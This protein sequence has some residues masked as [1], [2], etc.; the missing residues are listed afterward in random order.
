MVSGCAGLLSDTAE[1]LER[2]QAICAGPQLPPAE[3]KLLSLLPAPGT[4]VDRKTVLRVKLAYTVPKSWAGDCVL[5]ARFGWEEPGAYMLWRSNMARPTLA[6]GTETLSIPLTS[7]VDD[8]RML[9]P[10]Q[11]RFAIQFLRGGALVA[12]TEPQLYGPGT[13]A[14]VPTLVVRSLDPAPDEKLSPD[15][16]VTALLAYNIPDFVPGQYDLRPELDTVEP[17]ETHLLWDK[18][19]VVP[20][21]AASGLAVV[22]V[23]LAQLLR[24]PRSRRPLPLS[25]AMIRT[26]QGGGWRH[27]A[28]TTPARYDLCRV[29]PPPE[30]RSY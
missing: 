10:L 18:A 1:D 30:K 11:V 5:A 14:R 9:K 3:L 13:P 27:A 16:V 4:T 7:L 2:L 6:E 20:L 22:K 8:P 28:R 26:A 29:I 24:V 25:F 15:T 21:T 12:E 17:G 19:S 23:P